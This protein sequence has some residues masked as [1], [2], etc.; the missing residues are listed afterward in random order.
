VD[1][2]DVP[3]VKELIAQ[4]ADATPYLILG[5]HVEFTG[6]CSVC[7]KRQQTYYTH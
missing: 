1:D 3:V 2:I 6:I 5:H 4:A 7:Q